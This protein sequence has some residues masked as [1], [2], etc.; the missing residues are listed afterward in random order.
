M[1]RR[2]SVRVIGLGHYELTLNGKKV[3]ATVID[4]AWSQY[5]KRLYWQ[6]F[7]L[8]PHLKKGENVFGVLLGNSF[9]RVVK[10]NNSDR[11]AKPDAMPDFSDGRPF[12][13]WLDARFE[14]AD[15]T[16][17]IV[18]SDGE[19]KWNASPLTF[20]NVYG[21]EDWDARLVQDGWDEPG[22]DDSGWTKVMTVDAP[23]AKTSLLP[24]VGIE[25]FER[26]KPVEI[27][28]P[29]PD[30]TTYVFSQNCSALLDFTVVGK[31]GQTIRLLPCEYLDP[32]TKRVKFTY[33]SGTGTDIYHDY[34][35]RGGGEERHKIKFCYVGAQY[36][37][38]RG[39]V[40]EGAPNP[41]GLPVVKRIEMVHTRAANALVGNFQCSSKMQNKAFRMIDWSIRSNMSYVPTDCP[42]REK[43]GWQEEIW[44]MARAISYRFG[45]RDWYRKVAQD[46]R[47]EQLPDGHVPT[48][49]PNVL[50]GLGPHGFWNEAP[51]W[52]VSS[53]L[54]PWHLYEWYGD[55][56]TLASSYTSMKRYVDYLTWIEKDGLVDSNLGDWYDYGHGKGDGPAQW[57]PRTV[58]GTAVWALGAKT[59]SEAAAV[60][61]NDLDSRRYRVLFEHIRASFIAHF[62]D[63][64]TKQVKN[65]GSCQPGNSVALCVGLVPEGDR[66]GALQAVIDDL[67]KRAWQQTVGEVLQVFFVRALG[68][69]GR[70]DVLHKVYARTDRGSYG[71]MVNEGLTT[72][73]ESWDAK[74][75]T[76]NSMNH[77]MLGHLMEWHF[78]FVAG[79][80][81]AT[82][83]VGW[84][85]ALIE[86]FPGPLESAEASFA[87]PSG[88]IAVAWTSMG[89][90]FALEVTM[91]EGIDAEVRLPDGSQARQGPGTRKY[92]CA[93]TAPPL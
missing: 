45:I 63:S 77:F 76:G 33:T 87:S 82:G 60:L 81:Q 20:S 91:P 55:R 13:V 5:N 7:D 52:G 67:E 36:V 39:A 10:P 69:A 18:Q 19:W 84:K 64:A 54:V 74:P 65:N 71:F 58:S 49:V 75:G 1:P 3:G 44:H 29:E 9:Y 50:V 2:A 32:E 12:L 66:A 48:N 85:K 90:K 11:Y 4:Q 35:L 34:T 62:W 22:F 16:S 78:A 25:E 17:A 86:P 37:E 83:S 72:L 93:Y 14:S 8:L 57:T 40:P 41:K 23:S 21:G 53:V 43:T 61:G 79:I 70:S 6:E 24:F 47:D 27:E 38:V 68:D 28:Q 92:S 88:E 26:F 51:E 73:P 15:G 31:A 80:R 56:E 46:I 89:G 42:H 30:V 59:V